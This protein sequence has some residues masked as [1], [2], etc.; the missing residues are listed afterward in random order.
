MV[1]LPVF[2]FQVDVLGAVTSGQQI[3]A[4]SLGRVATMVEPVHFHVSREFLHQFS[5]ERIISGESTIIGVLRY[6]A[7]PGQTLNDEKVLEGLVAAG[8]FLL[9]PSFFSIF[10]RPA[11]HFAVVGAQ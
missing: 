6:G 1:R 7:G 8:T 5:G 2:V 3:F 9:L 11:R 4:R 10:E